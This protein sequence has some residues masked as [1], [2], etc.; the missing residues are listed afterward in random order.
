M[1]QMDD[2]KTTGRRQWIIWNKVRSGR[3]GANSNSLLKIGIQ[4]KE[5]E[6]EIEFEGDQLSSSIINESRGVASWLGRT[7]LMCL[8]ALSAMS[9]Y[10]Y[11]Q[12]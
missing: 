1:E 3:F 6:L 5:V 12:N 7:C 11:L 10:E 4:L 8:M 2:K 9:L